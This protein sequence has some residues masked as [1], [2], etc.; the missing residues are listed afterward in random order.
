MPA[1]CRPLADGAHDALLLGGL[2]DVI[3][4]DVGA[5][6]LE[7]VVA[8]GR[9]RLV[10]LVE[11]IELELG[12]AERAQLAGREPLD[13]ALEHGAR[14]MRHVVVVMVEHVGQHQ[15][16]AFEPGQRPQRR[17]VGL[18][19]E[20]AV[21]LVPARRRVARHR[22][23][24]DVVGEQVVAAVRL[25]VGAVDEVLGLEALADQP[26]LHVDHGD[27]HGIDAAG[28]DRGFQ[29][30]EP[31]IAGHALP[32]VSSRRLPAPAKAGVAGIHHAACS[33]AC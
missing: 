2:Q 17:Q 30:V 27:Q 1:P 16:R 9:R 24:V 15:R 5:G 3:V 18:Q 20:I 31:E 33:G 26:A 21:A 14:R 23:H 8:L 29:L 25:L 11:Q 6:G 22:L 7:A 10:G 28:L 13:L 12:G 32:L 4:L 19:D